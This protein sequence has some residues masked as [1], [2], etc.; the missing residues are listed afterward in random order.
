MDA[1]RLPLS[2]LHFHPPLEVK[3][4]LIHTLANPAC[5]SR[6]ASPY[7]LATCEALNPQDGA[8]ALQ[9]VESFH[10]KVPPDGGL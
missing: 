4:P 2:L 5:K 9:S 8:S 6:N 1:P 3:N 7:F 10:L